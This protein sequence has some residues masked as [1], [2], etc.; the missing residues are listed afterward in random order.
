M[1]AS[2]SPTSVTLSWTAPADAR[3]PAAGLSYNLRIGTTPGGSD[4]L[5]PMA[6]T[7]T[8]LAPH[9]AARHGTGDQLDV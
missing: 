2:Y 7:A 3:T 1:R 5:G 6:D 9:G 8:G 4:I